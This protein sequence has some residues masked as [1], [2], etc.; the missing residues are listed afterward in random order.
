MPRDFLARFTQT[1]RLLKAL[2]RLATAQETQNALL[3]RLV[4]HVC[5]PEVVSVT[6]E[7]LRV[8]SGVTFSRDEEQGR[9]LDFIARMER[10][11]GH[12]PTEEEVLAFLDGQTV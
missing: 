2:D 3:T 12:A 1:H 8:H 6:P 10:D 4:T 7:E 9:I 5:G 11:T